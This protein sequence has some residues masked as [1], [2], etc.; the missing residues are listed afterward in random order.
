[1]ASD[2]RLLLAGSCIGASEQ[3]RRH[4]RSSFVAN[5]QWHCQIGSSLV[6]DEQR[7]AQMKCRIKASEQRQLQIKAVS[8]EREKRHQKAIRPNPPFKPTPLRVEQD[9][10]FF[11]NWKSANAFPIYRRGATEWH[12]VRPLLFR[13]A[14]YHFS[15]VP[16]DTT[17]VQGEQPIVPVE[18]T[19]APKH[20]RT[21]AIK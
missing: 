19:P 13:A 10:G 1:M 8:I 5:E 15:A 11:D 7:P 16:I 14:R 12:S 4:I 6:A 18:L 9:R 21:V 3:R 17:V 20:C 2:K